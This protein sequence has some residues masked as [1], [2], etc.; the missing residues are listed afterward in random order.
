MK[1]TSGSFLLNF[2]NS[3]LDWEKLSNQLWNYLGIHVDSQPFLVF[4]HPTV[5]VPAVEQMMNDESFSHWIYHPCIWLGLVT[6]WTWQHTQNE[7]IQNWWRVIEKLLDGTL[8]TFG[9]YLCMQ[10]LGCFHGVWMWR[11]RKQPELTAYCAAVGGVLSTPRL[12]WGCGQSCVPPKDGGW[13]W[14][15]PETH[16]NRPLCSRMLWHRL[17]EQEVHSKYI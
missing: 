11:N 15:Q 7:I 6:L 9:F 17:E 5:V 14:K 13:V 3:N 12:C 4:L 16:P 10:A 1:C 2:H 8:G